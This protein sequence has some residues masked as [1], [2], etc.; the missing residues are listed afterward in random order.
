[1]K[2]FGIDFSH[3]QTNKQTNPPPQ[4]IIFESIYQCDICFKE[5]LPI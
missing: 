4:K 5:N 3:K 2:S 1:M